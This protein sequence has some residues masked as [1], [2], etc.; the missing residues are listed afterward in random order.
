MSKYKNLAQN[1]IIFALG[2]V[3]SK[4]IL[5][6]LL[7]MYTRV[8]TKAEY[9]TAELIA[10][11]AQLIVPIASL[12]ISDALF[13]YAAGGRQ[14]RSAVLENAF[15]VLGFGSIVLTASIPA[16]YYIE[17]VGKWGPYLVSICIVS[18]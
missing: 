3:F 12:S 18:M 17:T 15:I 8:L 16:L 4:L 5:S 6:L 7:P 13:R 11:Y 2:N 9:G 10:S 14:N 1:T